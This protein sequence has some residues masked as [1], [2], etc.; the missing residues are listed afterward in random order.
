MSDTTEPLHD[1]SAPVL[2]LLAAIAD[3]LDLALPALTEKDERDAARITWN[4][5]RNIHNA[6]R[7]ILDDGH[8]VSRTA[9]WIRETTADTPATYAPWVAP[10]HRTDGGQA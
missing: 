10:E 4:R 2:D 8:K 5:A 1:L 7:L 3:S 9:D 6:V